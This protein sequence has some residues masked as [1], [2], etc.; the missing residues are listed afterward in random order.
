M[1]LPAEYI[2]KTR[3][4]AARNS[5]TVPDAYR[6]EPDEWTARLVRCSRRLLSAVVFREMAQVTLEQTGSLMLPAIGFYYSLFHAGIAML[7]MDH[8]TSLEELSHKA[9]QQSAKGS[10]G[11]GM[12]H[13]KLRDLLTKRLVSAKLIDKDFVDRLN[14]AKWLREYVNYSVGGRLEG[15]DAVVEHDLRATS[16]YVEIGTRLVIALSF[17]KD[18]AANVELDSGSGHGLSRIQTTIGDHFGDDLIQLYVPRQY[19]ERV[20]KFLIE[21]EVT[22]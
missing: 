20:W 5:G 15:D 11:A 10:S 2:R 22:T 8:S 12:T 4:S 14:K 7:Y 16:L 19:R 3:E 9:S 21:H 1:T 17:I 18:V 13:K 6:Y